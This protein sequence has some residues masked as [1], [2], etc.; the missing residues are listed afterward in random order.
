MIYKRKVIIYV[1]QRAHSI[2][3]TYSNNAKGI[4]LQI[5]RGYHLP[6][7]MAEPAANLVANATVKRILLSAIQR[8]QTAELRALSRWDQ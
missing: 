4:C 5:S 2:A 8:T 3:R 7:R 6:F 1:T